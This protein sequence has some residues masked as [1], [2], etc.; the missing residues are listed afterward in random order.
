MLPLNSSPHL[1]IFFPH[2]IPFLSSLFPILVNDITIY[3]ATQKR[4]IKIAF[5]FHI[6]RILRHLVGCQVSL[7]LFLNC[8]T[9][10]TSLIQVLIIVIIANSLNLSFSLQSLLHPFSKQFSTAITYQVFFPT[11]V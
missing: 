3:S 9:I 11:Q 6:S 10:P 4:H 5:D 7:S 1:P 2:Q 8:L